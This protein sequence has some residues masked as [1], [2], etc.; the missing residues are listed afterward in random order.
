M[1]DYFEVSGI[2][3]NWMNEWM[4]EW[5]EQVLC[6]FKQNIC[7]TNEC[8]PDLHEPVRVRVTCLALSRVLGD[9]Y[10]YA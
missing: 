2:H 1:A 8:F 3:V 5:I 9:S 7:T 4:Y 6:I 10:A